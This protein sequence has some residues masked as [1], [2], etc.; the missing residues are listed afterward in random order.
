MGCGFMMVACEDGFEVK[1]K[2]EKEL[3]AL[4]QR[5]TENAH[6]KKVSH[7]DVMKMAK[8]P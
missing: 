5:H 3:V 2:D 6:H 4:T 7:A 8:H 1:T